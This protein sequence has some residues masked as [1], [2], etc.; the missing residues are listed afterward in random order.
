M[1]LLSPTCR[2]SGCRATIPKAV[3]ASATP[4]MGLNQPEPRMIFALLLQAGIA[5]PLPS[6]VWAALSSSASLA[7][8]SETVEFLYSGTGATT[9]AVT[10][11]LTSRRLGETPK[12]M[13]AN[14]RTCPGAAEAVKGLRLVPMPTPIFPGDR[15][16][17]ILDGVGYR[18][19]F[20]AHY[21]S[22]MGLPVELSSNRG[23]S[24]ARWVSDTLR[25]LK[26]CWS[27]TRPA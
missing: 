26:P 4:S 1:R 21:G 18:V 5:Q 7:H 6:D 2:R 16:E 15:E 17:I 19:R 9:D 27:A 13:W 20:Q 10:L 14:S 11:R 8:S 24:L 3:V 22:E 23:T 12:I 25:K